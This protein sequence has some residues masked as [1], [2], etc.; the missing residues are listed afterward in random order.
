MPAGEVI[1]LMATGE[2]FFLA[3]FLDTAL[4]AM[5]EEIVGET[6]AA[7]DVFNG[8]TLAVGKL[9]LAGNI[10]DVNAQQP[11]FELLIAVAVGDIDGAYSTIKPTGG[12]EVGVGCLIVHVHPPYV[13]SRRLLNEDGIR[14]NRNG[15][16]K[17]PPTENRP[18]P[19]SNRNIRP[20]PYPGAA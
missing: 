9:S 6:A 7:A 18:G 19:R 12:D 20:S 15:D 1:A 8:E 11:L 13:T 4:F 16:S 2:T 17:P 5:R 14:L 3:A 10:P